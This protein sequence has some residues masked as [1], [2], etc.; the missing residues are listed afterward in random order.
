MVL[1]TT[2]ISI[3]ALASD[4]L[5]QTSPRIL[6]SC[7][8][9]SDIP[10]I[11]A[12]SARVNDGPT[13]VAK[14][15]GRIAG[16][17]REFVGDGYEEY[18]LPGATFE[19]TSGNRFIPR[20][21]FYPFF[22]GQ[23]CSPTNHCLEGREF[24][25]AGIQPSWLNRSAENPT[26]NKLD[27]PHRTTNL[28]CGTKERRDFCYRSNNFNVKVTFY[29]DLQLPISFK[30]I[31]A[32]GSAQDVEFSN[33]KQQAL[34]NQ[35]S[36]VLSFD[37]TSLPR[38]MVLFSDY[39]ENPIQA[40][41]ASPYA[42]Y[43]ADWPGIWI[44]GSRD[45]S[46]DLLNTCRTIP[47]MSVMTNGIYQEVPKWNT[48]EQSIDLKLY[49]PHLRIDGALNRGFYELRISEAL[50][51][52]FW[53]I[54]IS[55]KTKARVII[56][57]PDKGNETLVETVSMSFK[58]SILT[59]VATNFTFSA[60][61]IRTQL[62]SEVQSEPQLSVEKSNSGDASPGINAG[63]ES[64]AASPVKKYTITCVKGKVSKKITAIKPKCPKGF[65]KK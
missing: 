15:T 49:A 58:N 57:Y 47:F 31:W 14:L 37:F 40:I 60:P 54:E 12:I 10:C 6:E 13:Q 61:T 33:W 7:K 21:I 64:N 50:A 20:I 42:D 26:E 41:D 32:S 25:A 28:L 44:H 35:K 19:G 2:N 9:G 39:Y 11:R 4:S 43:P 45:R 27:L 29:V 1:L 16:P 52:C 55:S 30:P 38:Q 65:R 24:V 3:P 17:D 51:K 34:D 36:Y 22:S 46:V 5:P 8:V 23:T 48:S 56:V 63:K 18:E 62:F 53:N 59:V